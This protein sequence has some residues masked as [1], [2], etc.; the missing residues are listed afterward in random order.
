MEVKVGVHTS[1]VRTPHKVR[2]RIYTRLTPVSQPVRRDTV[3]PDNDGVPIPDFDC[4]ES[5]VIS[6]DCPAGVICDDQ[7]RREGKR[8]GRTSKAGRDTL[9]RL[10]PRSTPNIY[11]RSIARRPPPS[12][13]SRKT[14][15]GA[16]PVCFLLLVGRNPYCL[17]GIDQISVFNDT[18]IGFEYLVV[19]VGI[20]VKLLRDPG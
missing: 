16:T 8:P 7:L 20:T 6:R 11:V 3:H 12:E 9:L 2:S 1:V 14:L 13:A 15:T 18:T 19:L 10:Q 5:R 4:I 17:P